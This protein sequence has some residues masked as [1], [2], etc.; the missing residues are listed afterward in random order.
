V[1]QSSG[2]IRREDAKACLAAALL[3]AI[4]ELMQQRAEIPIVRAHRILNNRHS[5]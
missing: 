2:E 5:L 4:T 1:K 3:R